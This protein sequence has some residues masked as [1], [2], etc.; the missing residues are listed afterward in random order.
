MYRCK[1][2]L[3][4]LILTMLVSFCSCGNN[5]TQTESNI[6]YSVSDSEIFLYEPFSYT[7]GIYDTELFEW[8][9]LKVENSFFQ[10]FL[11][12]N[13]YPYYVVGGQ[14]KNNFQVGMLDDTSLNFYFSLK[15]KNEALAPFATNGEL[16]FYMIEKVTE[17]EY[18]KKVVTISP[19]GTTNLV[20]NLDGFPV[21]DGVI[22][23]KYL[24]FTCPIKDSDLYEIWCFDLSTGNPNQEPNLI[25][26]DYNSYRLYSYRDKLLCID[27]SKKIL[28]NDDVIINLY[29]KSDLVIINE[30]YDFIAEKYAT[31]EGKLE[32]SFTAIPSGKVLGRYQNAINFSVSDS[33]ITIYGKGFIEYLYLKQGEWLCLIYNLIMF[34]YHLEKK[35]IK[36]HYIFF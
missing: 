6:N 15:D 14:Y 31:P 23:G 20:A 24:Y 5:D 34:L 1:K 27:V 9:P 18:L 32:I 33:V 13:E 22:A 19:E 2:V 3:F 21:M 29:Q 4:L 11:W 17:N 16:F 35:S 26:N 8:Q 10:S 12:G 25:C 28:Y 30:K 36:F 7:L